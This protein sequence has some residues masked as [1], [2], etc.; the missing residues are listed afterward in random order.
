MPSDHSP[1]WHARRSRVIGGSEI[2]ALYQVQQPYQMGLYAL[3]HYKA[4][5][6]DPPPVDNERVDWGNRLE[7]II[8]EWAADEEGWKT[9]KGFHVVDATT[10]G[11][12]CTL[13]YQIDAPGPNDE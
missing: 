10:P 8:A 2:A 11:L 12:G 5:N 3:W 7:A 9:T 4:G 1:D 13:D 6:I